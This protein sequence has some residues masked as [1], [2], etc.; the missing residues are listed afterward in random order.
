MGVRRVFG[1]KFKPYRGNAPGQVDFDNS[2]VSTSSRTK[3]S[4]M[5]I[6]TNVTIAF[7]VFS[8]GFIDIYYELI[9]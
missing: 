3:I 1:K 8:L 2:I 7:D 4:R 6:I 5:R 9:I